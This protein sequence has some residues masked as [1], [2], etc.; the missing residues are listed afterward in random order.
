MGLRFLNMNF[1]IGLVTDFENVGES[2]SLWLAEA[3]AHLVAKVQAKL[4]D[5]LASHWGKPVGQVLRA[6]EPL[7][8]I[9]FVRF[10]YLRDETAGWKTNNMPRD[11]PPLVLDEDLA[12][13]PTGTNEKDHDVRLALRSRLRDGV[14]AELRRHGLPIKSDE[15][16]DREAFS[17]AASDAMFVWAEL[18]KRSKDEQ[19]AVAEDLI[20]S[21]YGPTTGKGYLAA[22]DWT[23][24]F[25]SEWL[26]GELERCGSEGCR[27]CSPSHPDQPGEGR[28]E[29]V[30]YQSDPTRG[31]RWSKPN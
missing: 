20:D 4:A 1:T 3:P 19:D 16:I 21:H 7:D 30:R 28:E 31:F 9:M 15:S 6:A 14:I 22:Q 29:D 23:E 26:P 27:L 12:L 11:L 25:L 18:E 2:P 17:R 10:L 24:R 8:F 13:L 5:G